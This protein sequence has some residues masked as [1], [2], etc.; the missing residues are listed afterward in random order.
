MNYYQNNYDY[1]KTEKDANLFAYQSVKFS[2]KR[3]DLTLS[4]N[5]LK[6]LEEENNLQLE[7]KE[8][9]IRKYNGEEV[10]F[11]DLFDK[12]IISNP[13]WLEKYPQL[14]IEYLLDNGMVRRKT[15]EEF[16]E[17]VMNNNID[18]SFIGYF[19]NRLDESTDQIIKTN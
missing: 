16:V 4:E 13:E 3:L 17:Y 10:D 2:L 15:K 8:N 18:P 6:S 12:T 9:N 5:K 7:Q 19:K 11:Y 14:N 1:V